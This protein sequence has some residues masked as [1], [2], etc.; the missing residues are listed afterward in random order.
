MLTCP[1][2]RRPPSWASVFLIAATLVATNL[3][4]RMAAAQSTFGTLTG[5]VTDASG[6]VL[7]GASVVATHLA[8]GVER[9]AVSD[10][11]G[12]FQMP[13]LDAGRYRVRTRLDGFADQTREVELLARQI[14]RADLQLA[15]AGSQETV[16]VRATRPVIESERATIDT[17]ISGADIARLALN[18]RAT[19]ETSPIVVATLSQ[20]VQQ[21]R[22][23]AISLAGALPFMTSFS[24][25]GISTQRVRYG[26]PSRELFPSVESIEEF[27]VTTA[28]SSAEFMQ[29]TDITTTSRSGS[30]RLTGTAFWFNQD[31]SRDATSRFTPRDAAGHPI[32]PDLQANSY[33]LAAGGPIVRGRAFFFGT[34]EAAR[35]PNEVTLSQLVPP[36]AWRTGD[37]SSESRIIRNPATGQPFPGNRVPVNP[38]S[39]KLLDSFYPRQ[40]QSTGSAINAP[41]YI[42]NA[43]GDYSVDG[44]D[45]RSDVVLGPSQK[46]FGRLTWKNVDDMSPSGSDW[47]T[48]QGDHFKRTEVRQIAGAHNW[49]RGNFVN[50]LRG[51]WSNTVEKD[52]YTSAS[53]G[54][55]LV[56]AAGLVGLP[57]APLTGGFPHLE[58]ADG[59]FI[60][61]GGVKP[62]DILSRVVQASDTLTWL[63]GRH[64]VKAGFDLQYV[65]YRD[66]ISFFDGE[67]LGRYVFDGS[68]TGQAFADFLLGVPRTTGYILPAPDVN[69]FATYYAG[70]VQDTWRPVSSLTIDVGLRY[71][72]R[73]PM[74]DRSNQ[75]GNFDTSFPGGRVIVSDEAGLALVPDFVRQS[76]PNTPFV[77]ADEAGLPKTLRRT[78][79]NNLS[80]RLSLAWRPKS[81][82][83]TVIRGA[84]GLYTVPLLGSVNYSMVATVTAAAVGY[85]ND[86]RNPFVF[87]NISS[88]G[89]ADG[90]VPPGTLDF[91][92]ANQ[93]DMRDPRTRQWSL[94]LERDL[95][96]DFGVRASYIGSSTND[97]IWSPDLNQVAA[98]TQGYAA[99]QGTRPFTDWNVVTTRAN[100]P[101][102][103][104]HALGLELNKRLAG[105][106]RL[107][108]SYTVARHLSDAGGAVP[109][110]FAAENGA[111]TLN[112]FRGDADYGPVAFT[113]RHRFVS[114]FLYE[115]PIGR[116]RK[117]AG[118]IG[119]GLDAVIGG[120]DV[121]GVTLIQSGPFLTPS[122]SNG[123]P[124]GTGA[125]TRGFTATQRPDQ[126]RDGNLGSPTADAWFD[127][128][129]FA[130]PADN[131]GRFGN[132]EV[133]TLIGP[134]TSVFSMTLGKTVAVAGRS[135]VRFELAFS[136]LF[137]IENL[138]IPASLNVTSSAFGRITRTQ[139]V[140]QA[141]PRTLQL[142]LR[143]SF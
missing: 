7:P 63:K 15:L 44:F 135:R 77:T 84:V 142:S 115:L 68:F 20:G 10:P 37:L 75:L 61:T 109:T 103:T 42:V 111:T 110:A 136:N 88:A 57:G 81:S 8:T 114:T 1:T 94:T 87:P 122:F 51:G 34:Y 85:A 66:Q 59:S 33:G 58:F 104:Y 4:T 101:R 100:D 9:T 133:G 126:I 67:E 79:R 69:P 11:T 112:L 21:D 24:V 138:D 36:D 38:V 134:G 26:G 137:N 108:A 113:R 91:R 17:S 96:R 54:A 23:G 97:L 80:P 30:N 62:F 78:D 5:T 73:P 107:N 14:L 129:A 128:G 89:S 25:D 39:A 121:T 49:I 32:K 123:D 98:N 46:V 29:A 64:T 12:E 116:G 2:S 125:N 139:T 72:L 60:S 45:G 18:F 22:N 124:S 117:V 120:W 102:S 28:S 82:E 35:R 40:N 52:T 27:K 83:R 43:P 105:G 13:N 50:E 74:A 56:A 53:K 76:V 127:A 130:K 65:E 93:I 19:N 95:G 41:N 86:L 140:D 132:A 48:T 71:D 31:S 99:V 92:R 131:I 6:A 16:Q 119:R 90:P 70:F 55:D 143:Y 141:G 3:G 47:N 106:L 118:D